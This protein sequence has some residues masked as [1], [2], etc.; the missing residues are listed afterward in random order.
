[1]RCTRSRGPRGFFC[2]H[3]FRR[4]PVNAAV[5]PPQTCQRKFDITNNPFQTPNTPCRRDN[6]G[7][8][9]HSPTRML[10]AIV[11]GIS[12]SYICCCIAGL[13]TDNYSVADLF[14]AHPAFTIT[15]PTILTFSFIA[16]SKFV[17]KRFGARYHECCILLVISAIICV[18][19]WPL[20]DPS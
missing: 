2:L 6:G 1:M 5:M 16:S 17:Q 20:A 19:L 11:A 15:I 18:L 9:P 3:V 14:L 7:K 8:S 12:L 4:G 13:I 10:V